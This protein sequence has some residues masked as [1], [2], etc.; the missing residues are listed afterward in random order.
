[1]T[2]A[3]PTKIWAVSMRSG[4]ILVGW[5]Q[6]RLMSACS[7]G[8]QRIP[9]SSHSSYHL[10]RPLSRLF[11][12]L[13]R[14]CANDNAKSRKKWQSRNQNPDSSSACFEKQVHTTSENDNK[15][16]AGVSD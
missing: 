11:S 1:M 12:L 4:P 5:V 13:S 9:R 2:R 6:L 10:G 15:S 3:L 8:V 14:L 7:F 16:E